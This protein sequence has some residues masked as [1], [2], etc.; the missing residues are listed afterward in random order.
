MATYKKP[1]VHC[2][3]YIDGDVSFCPACGSRSPFGYLCPTCRTPVTREQKACANCGRALSVTCPSCGQLTFA[4]D[5]CDK[6]KASLL[7]QCN[8]PRCGQMQFFQNTKCTACGKRYD[9]EESS[10]V[11]SF[12]K[13]LRR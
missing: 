3:T 2:N 1:C 6:C 12:Y 5:T 10:Y 8:N 4:G 9:Q 11:K 7:I 13:K